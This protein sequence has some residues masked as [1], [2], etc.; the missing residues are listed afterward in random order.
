MISLYTSYYKD[1]ND[2]RQAELD[3][4]L[5]KNI[6]NPLINRIMLFAESAVPF[7]SDKIVIISDKRPTYQD[8]FNAINTYCQSHLE[9]SIIAN[10]DIYFDDLSELHTHLN[11][12]KCIALSRWDI[13]PPLPAKLHNERFS[14][15]AW[16]FQGKVKPIKYAS[17]HLGVPG[18]DNRIAWELHRAGY[19]L[20][21]PA[22]KIKCY[23]YHP[24]D[25]H[26]YHDDKGENI[27][28]L[29]IPKPYLFVE[30]T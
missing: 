18:C 14:Q 22:S 19:I 3:H 13:K 24:S 27:K 23:H 1:K 6:E 29:Y 20:K 15:D 7:E 21:N 26:T 11:G 4:C 28:Y 9:I 17:F 5:K 12:T 2:I 16:I 10:T 25:L 30:V 8:K